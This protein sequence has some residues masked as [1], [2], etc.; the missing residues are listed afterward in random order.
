MNNNKMARQRWIY[1]YYTQIYII[2]TVPPAYLNYELCYMKCLL[3]M[4]WLYSNNIQQTG[5][6]SKQTCICY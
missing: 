6:S 4:H 1:T 2:L 5:I 3:L